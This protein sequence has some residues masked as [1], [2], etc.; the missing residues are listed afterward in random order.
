MVAIVAA[1]E[2]VQ[3]EIAALTVAQESAT[4]PSMLMNSST[5]TVS[6]TTTNTLSQLL[7]ATVTTSKEMTIL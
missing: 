4:L 6:N 2:E 5:T 7:E 3:V 1:V